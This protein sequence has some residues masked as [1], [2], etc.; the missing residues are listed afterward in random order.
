[1]NGELLDLIDSFAGLDV[2]V[3]GDVIL[4]VYLEGDAARLCR[5]APVP[6]V[7]LESFSAAAGGAA[8]AA[9]NLRSLGARTSLLTVLGRDDDGE[10][11]REELARAGVELEQLIWRKTRRTIAKRRVVA[12]SQILLRLD[13]GDTGD[14]DEIAERLLLERLGEA[15]GRYDAILISDYAYGVMTPRVL[16]E[17]ARLQAKHGALLVV[18]SKR[19]EAFRDIR[20]TAVKPNYEEARRLLGLGE[21][22]AGRSRADLVL[23]QGNRILDTTGSRVAAVTLDAE[24]GVVFERGARPYRMYARP[25]SNSRANGAGDTFVSAL[26]LALAAGGCV[27]AAAELASIAASV[28]VRKE[29]T[30]LCSAKELRESFWAADKYLDVE[31]LAEKLELA[32]RQGKRI[33][34]TNGCFDILHQGHIAYLSRAKALGDLLVVGLNSD[35]SVR[36]LKGPDRPI[37]RLEER[38]QVLASLSCIDHIVPFDGDTA[39]ELVRRVRPHVFVKG[40]DY[41][42]EMLPEAP[43]VE[44]L[45][46]RIHLLPYV[47]DRSTSAII[48]RIRTRSGRQDGT[49]LAAEGWE[50][51]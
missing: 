25:A 17:L 9:T 48:E 16:K 23:G 36:R 12:A 21:P 11:L 40:G 4:D 33:V 30:A 13:E 18:D 15:F 34:F 47:K 45:G 14:I 20:P 19:P 2:L 28:A 1:M 22:P 7:T 43:V 31:S 5:E 32:R 35:D 44:E 41:T 10:M 37:N 3:V 42:V 38:A 8:N 46:G 39:I 50:A 49:T 6:V 51:S 27:P 24:G 26:T 29:G